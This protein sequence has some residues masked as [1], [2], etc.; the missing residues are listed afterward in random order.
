MGRSGIEGVPS[1]RSVVRAQS[2]GVE[3]MYISRQYNSR[4]E[5]P[6]PK[7]DNAV[8][9]YLLKKHDKLILGVQSLTDYAI[10]P[11]SAGNSVTIMPSKVTIK[12]YGSRV[13]KGVGTSSQTYDMLGTDAVHEA[14]GNYPIRDQ[15]ETE[16]AYNYEGSYLDNIIVGDPNLQQKFRGGELIDLGIGTAYDGQVVGLSEGTAHIGKKEVPGFGKY[17]DFNPFL[18][19]FQSV[20]SPPSTFPAGDKFLIIDQNGLGR[21]YQSNSGISFNNNPV[22]NGTTTINGV[23]YTRVLFYNGGSN[24]FQTGVRQLTAAI[25]DAVAGH[26]GGFENQDH[27][28]AVESTFDA[29]VTDKRHVIQ[30]IPRV[31][32]REEAD[33]Y[34][35][36]TISLTFEY[37]PVSTSYW[38]TKKDARYQH[39]G[40]ATLKA[41]GLPVAGIGW[42]WNWHRKSKDFNRGVVARSAYG[43]AGITGSFQKFVQLKEDQVFKYDSL[44]IPTYE[45][46]SMFDVYVPWNQSGTSNDGSQHSGNAIQALTGAFLPLFQRGQIINQL[47]G[48]Y[49]GYSLVGD[50]GEVHQRIA[51]GNAANKGWDKNVTNLC[52]RWPFERG[53]RRSIDALNP[54][55]FKVDVFA[56]A[57]KKAQ[58]ICR[59]NVPDLGRLDAGRMSSGSNVSNIGAHFS[60]SLVGLGRGNAT[61]VSTAASI[62]GVSTHLR[63]TPKMQGETEWASYSPREN[64][65]VA[66][67][68]LKALFGFETSHFMRW[69][70]KD[71]YMHMLHNGNDYFYFRTRYRPSYAWGMAFVDRSEIADSVSRSHI[72]VRGMRYGIEN[73][74]PTEDKVYMRYN[75]YGQFRD[76][77]EQRKF[78]ASCGP[79]GVAFE[80]RP[81]QIQFVSRQTFDD[82][83]NV[84]QER[85]FNVAPETTNS[86]NLSTYATASIPFMDDWEISSLGSSIWQYGR[87][88]DTVQPDLQASITSIQAT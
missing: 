79:D 1:D 68:T 77:L 69:G 67:K 78:Y 54:T 52:M 29:T 13:S 28:Y 65:D 19:T 55:T 88:R 50:P 43:T 51:A 18:P 44:V 14:I 87:D 45:F 27:L 4:F 39:L 5:I 72:V 82:T 84:I 49:T 21:V 75:R 33:L 16:P 70:T 48:L 20:A 31:K 8:S 34:D 41:A 15:F 12:L 59:V 60:A 42:Q 85:R 73:Y 38:T 57:L 81:V 58:D 46:L 17:G 37:H 23:T 83:G 76:M 86:Q 25:N 80:D 56:S 53:D 47:G 7:K 2:P 66:K 32:S 3:P 40:G 61:W 22:I 62:D 26:S 11:V 9:P 10:T 30:I 63:R 64:P 36:G 24:Q 35:D 74:V 71:K 6:Q